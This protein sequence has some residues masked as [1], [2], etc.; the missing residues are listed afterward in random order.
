MSRKVQV[1]L[2]VDQAEC[3]VSALEYV[4]ARFNGHCNSTDQPAIEY[5]TKLARER[6]QE[7]ANVINEAIA[8]T[9]QA[10]GA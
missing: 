7:V 5:A 2:R 10:P 9:Q 8:K 6:A 4:I 1:W 3:A